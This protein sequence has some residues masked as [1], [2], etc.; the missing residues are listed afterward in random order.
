M[1]GK[2]ETANTEPL[3]SQNQITNVQ[4]SEPK[5]PESSEPQDSELQQDSI[6]NDDAESEILA[7]LPELFED[8]ED[9][10]EKLQQHFEDYEKKRVDA[11]K[12][13]LSN[14][15][16][17]NY[18]LFA[19]P[20]EGKTRLDLLMEY[21]QQFPGNPLISV[22]IINACI[23]AE[24][25][26]CSDSLI[27][28]LVSAD[29]NNGAPHVS[30]TIFYASKGEDDKVIEHIKHI[31]QAST[32]NERY[33]ERVLT[34]AQALAGAEIGDFRLAA[35]EGIGAVPFLS[36]KP[37]FDWCEKGLEQ[38]AISD[39]C[40]SLGA[41]LTDR[42]KTLISWHMGLGLQKKIYEALDNEEI[43]TA[44]E[45]EKQSFY[46][47]RDANA[48]T[49]TAISL[50][51]LFDERLLRRWFENIDVHGEVESHAM[52]QEEATYLYETQGDNALCNFIY[53]IFNSGG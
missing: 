36:Y 24:D 7:C 43:V 4:T 17:F 38:A 9:R 33:G 39:A 49:N 51:M 29:S 14:A 11:A 32:F 48:N 45:R 53:D 5:P 16:A 47:R 52:M 19:P 25:E 8:A 30:A 50:M 26:R 35:Y 27:D 3:Q 42:G 41:E 21:H 15:D 37:V 23:G 13:H 10:K 31:E 34:Y 12:R 40:I 1:T 46:Q 6:E 28:D 2:P 18:S 20:P 44:L 22:D